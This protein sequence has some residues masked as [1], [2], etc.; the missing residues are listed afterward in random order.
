MILVRGREIS[1]GSEDIQYTAL[2]LQTG[3]SIYVAFRG[4][5]DT[6][7][8]WKEDF[9]MAF[10]EEVPAQREAVKYIEEEKEGSLL[11]GGHSKGGNLAVYA[12]AKAKASV[13]E[14]IV[15]I[16]NDDGPGFLEGFLSSPGY[17]R[18]SDRI[19]TV[20]P[21]SSIIGMLLCRKEAHRVVDSNERG[22]FQ[23]DPYSWQVLGPDFIECSSL[24]KGALL[25]DESVKSW[26]S[27]ISKEERSSFID[28]VFDSLEKAD[29]NHTNELAK[30]KN[31]AIFLKSLKATDK[32]TGEMMLKVVKAFFVVYAEKLKFMQKIFISN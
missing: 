20:V 3:N 27:S 6:I 11:V 17:E 7:V 13:Q 29:V 10:S 18:I 1:S 15:S 21:R 24:S 8:G 25:F 28:T 4:T 16:Y 19:H 22:I 32:E 5:D 9:N 26:L 30:P 2:S 23:H 31:L 12:S 14:R